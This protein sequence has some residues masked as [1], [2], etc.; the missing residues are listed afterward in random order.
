MTAGHRVLGILA[1]ILAGIGLALGQSV[2]SAGSRRAAA[3]NLTLQLADL[4]NQYVAAGPG[5]RAA[6][7][8]RLQTVAALRRQVLS[9]L[10]ER[11]PGAVLRVA[12]PS[13]MRANLP[14]AVQGL[15]EQKV[16]LQGKLE[17]MYQDSHS[18]AR[19]RHFLRVG[20]QQLELHFAQDPPTNLPTGTVV[21]VRGVQL[22]QKVAVASGTSSTSLQTVSSAAL[23]NTFGAQNTL[24]ILVN[25]LDNT[26]Q[27]YTPSSAY[28]QT[29]VNNSNFY[30]E[31]SYGQTWFTGNVV[32]WYTLPINSTCNTGTIASYANQAV[33]AAGVNLSSYQ[34][35]VYAFP[36]NSSCGWWGTAY[37]G[38]TQAWVTGPYN[39]IVLSHELGH[40]LGLYHSHAWN[41]RPNIDTG[42]CSSIEYGDTLDMMGDSNNFA[43]G[44]FNTF[45]KERLGWL[46][47]G[48]SPPIQT[49]QSD[50]SYTI[51]P[52][53][54][55]DG[56]NKALKIAQTTNS[57]TGQTTWIYVEYRQA[58][59]FDS[60]L[61]NYSQITNGVVLHLGTDSSPNS[62]ELLDLTPATTS[63]MDVALDAGLSFTDPVSGATIST[64]SVNSSG[65]TV[66]V[67]LGSGGGST[68]TRANP[69]VSLSP[70]QSAW[71]TAGTTVPFT[72]SVK[73]NDSS[74]CGAS[75]FSVT[76]S[77][78]SGWTTAV[79]SPSLSLNPGAS[80]STTLNVTSPTGTAN[81][82][83]TV[84]ATAA[85]TSATNYTASASATYVI[86]TAPS[87]SITVSTN[88]SSYV[89]GQ[90]VSI[91]ASVLSGTSPASGQSLTIILTKANGSQVTMTATT[92][93]NGVATASYRLKRKDPTGTY[94]VQA[95]TSGTGNAATVGATTSF[96]VQ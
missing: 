10:M 36:N 56:T 9:A 13:S 11:D 78:P 37:V 71:V 57:S 34:R 32:G 6:V 47:Y 8:S 24:V 23:P 52:Y 66:S 51:G 84:G 12:I 60:F 33:T 39:I 25:F 72:V 94:R 3:E 90:M 49:V 89:V 82:F 44:D 68:C 46:N 69:S 77:A 93:S 58:L 53:E 38:G 45:Q 18:G 16:Q 65:A 62:S 67:T 26:T 2:Q 92:G 86:G 81:G 55:Q 17:V 73:N 74:G 85:N 4:H 30:L 28:N 43:G 87:L 21:R 61:S 91:T 59:G 76:G 64:T 50:G 14:G 70:S 27:P 35:F 54:A 88:Q 79:T 15:L 41:C 22:E 48:S 19:L 96:T 1:V 95:S 40:L 80:A 31:N 29:F 42:T 63:W 5:Q 20:G 83:Y 75:S 7:A